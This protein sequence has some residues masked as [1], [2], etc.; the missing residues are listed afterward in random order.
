MKGFALALM[1]LQSL[2]PQPGPGD[3]R[4]SVI[5]Y[6]AEKIVLLQV[7]LGFQATIELESDETIENVAIGNGA[8]WQAVPNRRGNLLFVK[9]VQMA[10]MTNLI[11]VTDL[12]RYMFDL[13]TLPGLAQPTPYVLRFRYPGNA[14]ASGTPPHGPTVPPARYRLGGDRALRPSEIFDDGRSTYMAWPPEAAIPAVFARSD[15]GEEYLV[16]A[17]MR[18]DRLVIDQI[19]PGYVFRID[20]RQATA[21][22]VREGRR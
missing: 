2:V 9:P 7:P 12:R 5:D 11:V 15:D 3:P 19:S 18:G 20:R 21:R 22:R 4:L 1:A 6:D 16:N 8:A 10:A 17:T 14:I 13:E